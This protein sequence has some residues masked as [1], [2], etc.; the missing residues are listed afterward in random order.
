MPTGS[1][2]GRTLAFTFVVAI[3]AVAG[4]CTSDGERGDASEG[5]GSDFTHVSTEPCPDSRF[6]CI[7]LAVPRDHFSGD[8]TTWDVT[9]GIQRAAVEA[10]GTFVTITGGPGTS[11][12]LLADAY[13]DFMAPEITDNFDIVFVDQRGIGA[14]RPLR[15]DEAAASYYRVSSDPSDPDQRDQVEAETQSFVDDC[16]AEAGVAEGDLP[17]YSTVQAV[18]DLEAFRTYLGVDQLH[19]YG[20]SYG[21]QYVQTYAAAHPDRVASLIVDGVVDLTVDVLD[22]YVEGA[23]AHDDAL[24]ATLTACAADEACASDAG[25][26][27][28]AA[29]DT[30]SAALD[31]GPIEYEYPMSDGTSQ[32]R[33]FTA[34]DLDL[35]TVGFIGSLGDRMLLQRAVGA[36]SAG[37]LVPLARMAYSSIF[38]NPETLDVTPDPSWSDAMYYA[39]ECQDY[40]FF[41]DIGSPR[42]RLDMWIDTAL[43]AGIEEF[44]L[45][46]IAFGDLPCL[47]WPG[48]GEQWTTT[49]GARAERPDPIVDPPYPTL[50]LT[51][52]TDA[53]TPVANAMRVFSRLEN[54]HLIVLQGGPH[55][56]F[57]WGYTC[58]DELVSTFIATG[59]PPPTRVTICDGDVADPYVPIAPEEPADYDDA[60]ETMT[61]IDNQL[62]WSTSY[63]YWDGAEA[64][65][66]GCDFGG[67]V[68]YAPTDVGVDVTLDACEF[69]EGYA[70]SGTGAVETETGIVRLDVEIPDGELTYET[71]T[72]G[73]TVR[74]TGTFEGREVT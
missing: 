2:V 57:D 14:S 8:A 37:N 44:R 31:E 41:A 66:E 29:Y 6:E 40:D 53:A 64:F 21:T 4:G 59:E 19:L 42:R 73:E 27:G 39:V 69:T 56:I 13:T 28:L 20:E 71:E 61:I 46:T 62:F 65:T 45:Q 50:V 30:L 72:D 7:T 17:Y 9:F 18:E 1:C 48:T 12:L 49:G 32:T 5:E 74:L 33:S 24:I 58:V 67:S 43:A 22:Y 16:V 10:K 34:N 70:V 36:A 60:I 54:S 25:G 11:G 23:Q 52:D 38:V 55:V 15:C 47:L 68:E 35:A 26:D 3:V 51:A 63:V